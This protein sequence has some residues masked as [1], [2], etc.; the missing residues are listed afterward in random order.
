MS[1]FLFDS[2]SIAPTLLFL[3]LI[4]CSFYSCYYGL[5]NAIHTRVMNSVAYQA[6]RPGMSCTTEKAV[7]KMQ[8]SAPSNFPANFESTGVFRSISVILGRIH[9]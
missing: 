5:D 8:C 2:K 7:Q 1:V 6:V 9:L 4:K 3:Q